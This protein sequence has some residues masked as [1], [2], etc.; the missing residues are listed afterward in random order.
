MADRIVRTIDKFIIKQ[1]QVRKDEGGRA[2][3]YSWYW[4]E[5]VEGR[6]LYENTGLWECNRYI[7]FQNG[8]KNFNI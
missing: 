3:W 8:I 2:S 6:L 7:E 4:V 1:C 5:D